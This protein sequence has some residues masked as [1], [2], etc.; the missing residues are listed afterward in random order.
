MGGKILELE[1]DKILERGREQGLEQGLEQARRQKSY[2]RCSKKMF[3]GIK[4]FCIL[5]VPERISK[6]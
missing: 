4:S 1:T 5:D 6:N 2:P 3:L